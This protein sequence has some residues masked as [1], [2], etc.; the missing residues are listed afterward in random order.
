ML[1]I[2]ANFYNFRKKIVFN[3]NKIV[4]QKNEHVGFPEQFL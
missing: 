3:C 1:P 4:E 2:D